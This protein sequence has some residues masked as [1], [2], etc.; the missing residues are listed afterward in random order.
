TSVKTAANNVNT[1]GANVEAAKA[2]IEATK[3]RLWNA[4]QN[5]NRYQNLLEDEAVTRQQFDQIKSDFEAQ[6]AQLEAQI[7]QYQS[8]IN[9]KTTS[10]LSVNE[11]QARLSMN[12]AE[13]KRA[14][15]ALE[16]IGRA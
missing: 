6:K 5:F 16:K 4:E 2:N 8:V 12:D 11:V 15:N 13:I 10:E 3:A 14:E 1:V 9:S 7:S